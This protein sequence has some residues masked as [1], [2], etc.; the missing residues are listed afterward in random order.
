[1]T[2]CAFCSLLLNFI[3]K[4]EESDMSLEAIIEII[5]VF[6]FRASVAFYFCFFQIYIC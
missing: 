3:E 5:I 2:N 4:P 1:M 6:I